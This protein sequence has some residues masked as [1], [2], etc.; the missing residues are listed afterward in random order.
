MPRLYCHYFHIQNS[1]DI[2]RDTPSLLKP[3]KPWLPISPFPLLLLL[4]L[5]LHQLPNLISHQNPLHFD[6]SV[7]Q[8]QTQIVASNF[9]QNQVSALFHDQVTVFSSN[10]IFFW[11]F[12][13]FYRWVF[14]N[15]AGGEDAEVS[16]DGKKKFITKEQE[17]EQ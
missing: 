14:R 1:I 2:P 6:P 10:S 12:L 15:F 11:V 7:L 17:P 13:L 16:K 8:E 3:H 9:M 5:Q 4:I